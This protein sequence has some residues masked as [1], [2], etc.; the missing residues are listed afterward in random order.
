MLVV[1]QASTLSLDCAG[2]STKRDV[3]LVS[4][5]FLSLS[6][7]SSSL[8]CLASSLSALSIFKIS[9][10]TV[11]ERSSSLTPINCAEKSNLTYAFNSANCAWL[12]LSS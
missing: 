1:I 3:T 2:S 8:F 6:F 10:P 7:A 9:G 5:R 11:A 4:S 12:G